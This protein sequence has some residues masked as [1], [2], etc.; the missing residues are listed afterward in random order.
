MKWWG[1]PPHS[2]PRQARGVP[3]LPTYHTVY[4]RCLLTQ[5]GHER[6][7]TPARHLPRVRGPD[8]RAGAIRRSQCPQ[9]QGPAPSC[10]PGGGAWA[11][12]GASEQQCLPRGACSGT[13]QQGG[14]GSHRR[15][16][17]PN[18]PSPRHPAP[19]ALPGKAS[20]LCRRPTPRPGSCSWA[21]ETGLSW[22]RRANNSVW[23]VFQQPCC[24][25]L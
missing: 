3:W 25:S 18:G 23:P 1:L 24:L 4:C 11:H 15:T 20:A 7:L 16:M 9:R 19:P 22:A 13:R 17:W 12:H 10:Q 5:V 8:S 21:W 2:M 6:L 14:A